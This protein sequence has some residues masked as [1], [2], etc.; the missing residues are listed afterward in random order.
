MFKFIFHIL[1]IVFFL[2]WIAIGGVVL[3]GILKFNPLRVIGQI[4][5]GVAPNLGSG[6]SGLLQGL[7][8]LEG[9]NKL[10]ANSAKGLYESLPP[11]KQACVKKAWGE[12]TLAAVL[13]NQTSLS[14]D[15]ISKVIGCLPSK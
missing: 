7:G 3:V 1:G 12:A 5:G 11:E 15:L 4:S 6:A 14:S 8:V 9:F 10:S 13:A 2:I